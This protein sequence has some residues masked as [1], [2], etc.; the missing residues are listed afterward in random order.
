MIYRNARKLETVAPSAVGA[1]ILGHNNFSFLASGLIS[2]FG[3]IAKRRIHI[4]LQPGIDLGAIQ[5]RLYL[6]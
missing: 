2:L 5:V 1:Q 6:N 3:D 4:D